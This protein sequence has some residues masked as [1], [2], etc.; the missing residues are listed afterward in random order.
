[1]K[2]TTP[3]N[4]YIRGEQAGFD[5]RRLAAQSVTMTPSKAADEERITEGGIGA[6][7]PCSLHWPSRARRLISQAGANAAS[8]TSQYLPG[9]GL[10]VNLPTSSDAKPLPKTP[11][12]PVKRD[13]LSISF[14]TLQ[15]P[16]SCQDDS[17]ST[18]RNLLKRTEIPPFLYLRS[19]SGW[20]YALS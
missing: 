17:R 9:G 16:K 4:Q 14:R 19:P 7:G 15:G 13:R 2:A 20:W 11:T 6:S 3:N 1:M 8:P 5:S 10:D 12:T 18:F